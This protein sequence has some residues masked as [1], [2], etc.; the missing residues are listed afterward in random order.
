MT[1]ISDSWG[2]STKMITDYHFCGIYTKTY[3][4]LFMFE[5]GS[6]NWNDRRE[7][8]MNYFERFSLAIP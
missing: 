4:E 2:V 1:K 6:L 7:I 5:V 8:I 3:T